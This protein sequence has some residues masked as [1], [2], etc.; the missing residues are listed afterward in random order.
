MRGESCSAFFIFFL[1]GRAYR[2]SILNSS[3]ILVT[4]RASEDY[5]GYQVQYAKNVL[6]LR[7]KKKTLKGSKIKTI[8]VKVGKKSVNRKYV[9]KYKKIFTRKNAG[10]K[11]KVQ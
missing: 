3:Q 9:K 4:W 7:S 11:A 5:D 6:F 2:S 8:Q 1:T 10:K